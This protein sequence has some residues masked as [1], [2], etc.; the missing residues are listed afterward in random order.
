MIENWDNKFVFPNLITASR[1]LAEEIVDLINLVISK[2]GRFMLALSGGNTPR[3]LY[4]LFASEF[5]NRI[6]WEQ[7]HLFWGDERYV[8]KNHTHSNFAMAY[9]SFISRVNIPQGNVHRIPVEDDSPEKSAEL[10]EMTLKQMFDI[11]K[12]KNDYQSFDLIL[13]GMGDDG[14]TASLFPTNPVLFEKQ[15]LVC[16]VNA[17]PDMKPIRRITITFPI[18]NRAN[19]VFFLISGSKKERILKLIFKESE[20]AKNIYPA[21]MVNPR[22]KTIWFIDSNGMNDLK[23]P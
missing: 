9:D 12:E 19:C 20:K 10:Y 14:H 7:V 17:P 11:S 16:A 5:S 1:V 6:P 2:K 4:G 8:P 13:L 15:R 22:G 3:T 23:L 21:A 18:I